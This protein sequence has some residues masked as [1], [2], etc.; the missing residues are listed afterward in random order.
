VGFWEAFEEL[1]SFLTFGEKSLFMMYGSPPQFY[2]KQ[3]IF[4]REKNIMLFRVL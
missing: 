3:D 4:F 2:F 1:L